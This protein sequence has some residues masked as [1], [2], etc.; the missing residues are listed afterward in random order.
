MYG[1]LRTVEILFATRTF[2]TVDSL[3][4]PPSFWLN[5]ICV[6]LL[7]GIIHDKD[8]GHF[9]QDFVLSGNQQTGASKHVP[10]SGR[11]VEGR[12]EYS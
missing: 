10:T 9:V 11:A 12:A 2:L 3:F 5:E 6:I 4:L 7:Q 8:K 1:L